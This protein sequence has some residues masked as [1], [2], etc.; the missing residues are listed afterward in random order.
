MNPLD[1]SPIGLAVALP[2]DFERKNCWLDEQIIHIIN[3]IR[4]LALLG[5]SRPFNLPVEAKTYS[6]S[7]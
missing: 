7:V 1:G 4:P 6:F 3:V 5:P 2:L